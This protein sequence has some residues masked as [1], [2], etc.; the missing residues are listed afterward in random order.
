MNKYHQEILEEI[1]KHS[2]KA[3][4]SWHGSNY[5]GSGHFRFNISNPEKKSIAK[6][7]VKN[8]Q[9]LSLKEFL[10]LLDS[11]YA[12][13]SYEEKTIGGYLLS[14]LPK[15][16]KDIDPG[17]LNQWLDYLVGWAEIDSLCQG[18]FTA[19]DLLSNWGE[20]E[21]VL[22]SFSTADNISKHRASLVLL[23][24]PVSQSNDQKLADLALENIE[25]LKRDKDILITKATSWLL[26]SLVKNHRDRVGKYLK[27]QVDNLPKIAIRETQRK[28][29]TGKK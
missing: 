9:N 12:G 6:V 25:R 19:E 3:G 1:K 2:G 29:D 21:K 13:R 5:L 22:R 18:N 27:D 11:L 16:R 7:W 17:F 24:G 20:W 28:L 14:F 8:H 10:L 15:L 4:N 26:R 23:T